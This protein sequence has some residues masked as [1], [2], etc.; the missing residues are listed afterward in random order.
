MKDEIMNKVNE[1]LQTSQYDAV[2]VFGS[3]NVQYLTGAYL[4]YPA[5]FPDRYMAVFW[6]KEE[7]PVCIV[8]LEWESSY[9]NLAWVN[10][11]RAYTE[12]PGSPSGIAEASANLAKNTVRKTGK[13]GLDLERIPLHLYQRLESSLEDFELVPCDDWVKELRTVKTPKE[14]EL[15]KDL[16]LRTDHGITGQAHHVL[17]KQASTEMSNTENIRIHAIERELDEVGHH[18]IAQAVAG[19]NTRKFW[20]GAPTFGVGKDRIPQLG[21]MMRMELVST[22]NGYWCNGA[23]M[24]VFGELTTEQTLAYQSLVALREIALETMKPGAKCKDVYNAMKAL[25]DEHNIPLVSKLA[26][27]AG[28]GVTNWEVPYISGGDETELKPGMVLVLCPVVKGPDDEFMMAKDTVLV[29]EEGAE[30]V[31][32]FKDWREPFIACYT[33]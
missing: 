6:P 20:P 3:D 22:L 32:W 2:L 28:I 16:A 19:P 24:L 21:E 30:I 31:G 15:I 33:F 23:R 12:K 7:D 10:K 8:P 5:S 25:A 9:L 1:S 4:H 18:A 11:T 17:I 14:I 13:I 26:L 27:G 29:T